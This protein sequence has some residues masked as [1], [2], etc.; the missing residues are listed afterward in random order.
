MSPIGT[1]ANVCAGLLASNPEA[2]NRLENMKKCIESIATESQ[3]CRA[4]LR[5]LRDYTRKTPRQRTAC[6]MNAVLRESVDLIVHDLRRHD[7][8]VRYQLALL[9]AIVSSDRIQLQHVMIDLLTN[10]RDAMLDVEVPRR[11]ILLRSRI[12]GDF[13]VVEV[14]DGGSGLP[15][16]QR[17]SIFEP[18]LP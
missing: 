17:G 15:A 16:S 6:G 3:R 7:V 1:F 4:I 9:T 18:S 13:V 8:K 2:P 14:A 5:R 12:E 10:A 11:V